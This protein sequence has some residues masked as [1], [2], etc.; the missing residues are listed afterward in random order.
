MAVA[1]ERGHTR[2]IYVSRGTFDNIIK[3]CAKNIF[4]KL[5][6]D[7]VSS[8]ETGGGAFPKNGVPGSVFS[9]ILAWDRTFLMSPPSWGGAKCHVPFS[10]NPE[11]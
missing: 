7:A 2:G 3:V 11:L 10:D 8:T 6:Q 5:T 4:A 9:G 1:H